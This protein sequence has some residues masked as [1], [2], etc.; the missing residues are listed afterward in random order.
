[1]FATRSELLDKVR[2]GEDS[3]L[4]L[5]E[6]RFA[7]GRLSAPHPDSLADELA[8]F[9]NSHGGVL[10][11]GVDD[12]N[13]E[14]LGIPIDKLDLVESRVREL[15]QD[16][17]NPQLAPLI[18]RL[19]LPDLTGAAQPVMRVDVARSLFVH[20]SPGGWFHRV[21]SSKRPMPPD[22]L[23]RLFQQRSQ[24]RIIR[25]DEQC[26]P[27]ARIEDLD[28]QL[29]KRFAGE[30]SRDTPQDLLQKLAMACTDDDGSIRPSVAGVLL[31]CSDPRRFMQNAFVQAV[32]YRGTTISPDDAGLYQR[33]A[34]DISGP[35]DAQIF[36]A[37]DFVSKNMRVAA[38]KRRGRE[39]IPQFDPVAVFEAVTNAVAHRDYSIHGSK[40]RLRLFD[41]RLEIYSPGMLINTM[42]VESL[43]YRQA[44]RNE[45]ITS[46][47]A[48]CPTRADQGPVNTYRSHVMD[49]RGEGVP[50]ILE[51]STRLSGRT[52]VFRMIDDSELLLLLFAA[53]EG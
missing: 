21:G 38:S 8:A 40:V 33:D 4:E 31:A 26:V 12:K 20:Q 51:R 2:L 27:E 34:Q 3:Y 24:A 9:A 36:S 50:I 35:L 41:D 46:L 47:L 44:S 37:C 49:K 43:P 5:K 48:R 15:C 17:I 32:A 10:V 42:S 22:Y 1:M 6:V 7:G 39:D 18:E 30:R 28:P 13:R 14:V 23:A 53:S 52:P 45:A 11:L 19:T 25:F 29:W 16:K